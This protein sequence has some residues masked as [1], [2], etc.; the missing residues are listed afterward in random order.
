MISL[1]KK[2][3]KTIPPKQEMQTYTMKKNAE[4][5]FGVP[6][7]RMPEDFLRNLSEIFATIDIIK[8]AGYILMD[9]NKELS[10][11]M[12]LDLSVDESH[13]REASWS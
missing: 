4:V 9:H 11:V 1:F 2:F 8:R 13:Q 7:T 3:K 5:S 6:H 12:A 10:Y